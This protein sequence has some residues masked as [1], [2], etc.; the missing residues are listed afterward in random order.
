MRPRTALLFALMAAS[1]A[2]AN[3]AKAPPQMT[4]LRCAD[5]LNPPTD[6]TKLDLLPDYSWAKQGS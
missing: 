4:M 1:S 5:M 6:V 2:S 3:P